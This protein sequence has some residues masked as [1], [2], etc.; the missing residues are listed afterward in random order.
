MTYKVRKDYR[1]G[2]KTQ[3]YTVKSDPRLNRISEFVEVVTDTTQGNKVIS[4]EHRK[5]VR[6]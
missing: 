4:Q 6:E 2:E 1:D 3:T 5:V